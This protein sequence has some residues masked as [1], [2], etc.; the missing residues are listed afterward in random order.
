MASVERPAVV[1]E[2]GKIFDRKL[3]D[4]TAEL[5]LLGRR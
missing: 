3:Q 2:I 4:S 5:N 1:S